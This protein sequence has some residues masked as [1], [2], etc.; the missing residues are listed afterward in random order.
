[1]ARATTPVRV[2]AQSGNRREEQKK[3]REKGTQTFSIA[4][5]T[6][7]TR[8]PRFAG[9]PVAECKPIFHRKRREFLQRI[10]FFQRFSELGEI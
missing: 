3:G 9:P 2:V 5:E 7:R 1:M 6:Q 8:I 10:G 4:P